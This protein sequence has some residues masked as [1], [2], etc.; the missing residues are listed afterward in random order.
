MT[1]RTV[2]ML[3]G[4]GLAM[5]L[6]GCSQPTPPPRVVATIA[7][8]KAPPPVMPLGG[9]P[10]IDT[11]DQ[12]A[13][14]SY[15]TPNFD[16]TNA[17]AVWHLRGALNVAALGCDQAGGGVV[18][19]YNVW[20][21]GHRDGLAAYANQYLHEWE[22]TGWSDWRDAYE[23]QQTRL[24][25]FYSQSPIRVAFCAAA[26]A[27]IAKVSTIADADLPAFARAALVRL[28]QPFIDFFTGV[29]AWRDYYAPKVSAPR[30]VATIPDEPADPPA[31]ANTSAPVPPVVGSQ[32]T[33]VATPS[34]VPK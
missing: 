29:D 16:M 22:V 6:A 12:R 14:G 17:A 28:D 23:N 4:T 7:P 26:R 27:E 9:Y 11:A 8:P 10:E 3:G 21:R 19:G 30:F 20:L 32:P 24:Y 18:D 33:P 25:N 15:V 2:L 5:G 34:D 13:D 1:L 31:A